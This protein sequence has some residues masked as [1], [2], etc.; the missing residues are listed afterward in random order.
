MYKELGMQA[1]MDRV[2]KEY[3]PDAMLPDVMGIELPGK[4]MNESQPKDFRNVPLTCC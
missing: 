2:L 1:D 4:G 3:L